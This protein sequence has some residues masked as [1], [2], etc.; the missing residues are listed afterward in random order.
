MRGTGI[1][2]NEEYKIPYAILISPANPA[3]VSRGKK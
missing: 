1:V 2:F 3:T